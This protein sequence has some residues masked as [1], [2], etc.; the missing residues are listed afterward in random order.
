MGTFAQIATGR[1]ARKPAKLPLP[2]ARFDAV[3]GEWEGPTADLAIVAIT[4]AEYAE[5]LGKA[6]KYAQEHGVTAP[7]PGDDLYE[8]GIMVHTLAAACIDAESPENDPKPFFSSASE[9]IASEVM[10]PEIVA[11][12]YGIQQQHQDEYNPLVKELSAEEFMA[13]LIATAGGNP[14]FFLSSRPGTQWSFVHTLASQRLSSMTH[15]SGSTG[16]TD[17]APATRD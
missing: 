9:I 1:R 8:R 4:E 17:A 15:E 12:L 3:R 2:H 5:I 10:T 6:R 13:G 16:P 14:G 11:Y 7:E